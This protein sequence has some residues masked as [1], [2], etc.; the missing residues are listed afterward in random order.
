MSCRVNRGENR[1]FIDRCYNLYMEEVD[2]LVLTFYEWRDFSDD[3]EEFNIKRLTSKV[4]KTFY[5]IILYD[6]MVLFDKDDWDL[7]FSQKT[8]VLDWND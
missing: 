2:D 5:P 1:Y 3:L 4:S 6:C 7:A 8:L